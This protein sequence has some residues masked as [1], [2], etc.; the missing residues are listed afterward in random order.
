MIDLI[1]NLRQYAY[2][3]Y[4]QRVLL[5][6]PPGNELSLADVVTKFRASLEPFP[7]RFPGD[8]SLIWASF[9]AASESCSPEG[10][11]FFKQFLLKQYYRNGLGNIL[12]GL[13][14]L[15]RI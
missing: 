3:I 4:L 15:K 10:Q 1:A 14:L 2:H 6:N 8:H 5:D 12:K 13:D 7:E 11:Q 9:I